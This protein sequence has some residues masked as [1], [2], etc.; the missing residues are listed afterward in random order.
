MRYTVDTIIQSEKIIV[1]YLRHDPSSRPSNGPTQTVG[2]YN[3]E[4]QI[5][6]YKLKFD[7]QIHQS[8]N[9]Q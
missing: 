9:W 5:W 6:K 3:L 8:V 4:I 2:T 1:Y 7:N